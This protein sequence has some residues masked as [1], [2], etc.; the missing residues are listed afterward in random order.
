MGKINNIKVVG[1]LEEMLIQERFKS[2]D[3]VFEKVYGIF[4]KRDYFNTL[5]LQKYKFVTLK[6]S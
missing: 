2:P 1:K 3:K 5:G 6:I 4:D